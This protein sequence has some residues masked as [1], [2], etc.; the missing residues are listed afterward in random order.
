MRRIQIL[1]FAAVRERVGRADEEL[2]LPSHIATVR[3]L[4]AW[5]ETERPA[6]RGA[7]DSVRF[8]VAE[9]FVDLDHALREGDVVA[10]LP[11]VSGG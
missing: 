7:L 9:E 11:P 1:Y 3:A 10:V 8:A 6:L 4:S 5:L 2:E